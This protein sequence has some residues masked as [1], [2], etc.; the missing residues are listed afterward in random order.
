MIATIAVPV[1][2]S[3][4]SLSSFS[5]VSTTY[6]TGSIISQAI[7][8]HL[9]DFFGRVPGLMVCF[10]LFAIGTTLCG[11]APTLPYFLLGRSLQGIGGGS[12]CSIT[13]VL[14]TDIVPVQQRA[15]LEGLGNLF[16][17]VVLAVGGIYGAFT[18]SLSSWRWAFLLQVPVIVVDGIVI[19]R[20]ANVPDKRVEEFSY[21]EVDIVGI[22]SL[23]GTIILSEYGL[24][25]A[26]TTMIWWSLPVAMSLSISAMCLVMF[27]YWESS[28]AKRPV[29]P[30]NALIERSVAAIQI[31][32]FLSTGCLASVF[33]YVP[34]FLDTQG[35]SDTEKS[36]RFIPLAISFGL[37]GIITGHIVQRTN[38]YYHSNLV[39]QLTSTVAYAFLCTLHQSSTSWKPFLYL[40][41]LGFGVG[42]SYVTN[43]LGILTCVSEEDLTTIQSA[44]WSVRS[45]G[46]AFGLVTS[47][48]IFQSVLRA[49]LDTTELRRFTDDH[50]I[51]DSA[52]LSEISKLP[53]R[54]KEAYIK[55]YGRATHAVFYAL[56]AQALVG[57]ISCLFIQD[58]LVQQNTLPGENSQV[59]ELDLLNDDRN[60]EETSWEVQNDE[61][62]EMVN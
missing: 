58:R 3:L 51:Q 50:G 32:A 45:A 18:T 17:G 7:S 52:D 4:A 14:E 23:L 47:S 6:L 26:S 49:S 36:L 28:R 48:V 34:I 8:G 22:V 15:F 38:R 25:L 43:L 60:S 1:T 54:Y 42:G 55:G 9:V 37:S 61:P 20:V 21:H 53:N 40:G 29:V 13:S 59:H 62:R 16:Y 11:L 41:L 39:L 46:V 12:I 24:N 5:W 44:S 10:C 30:V 35:F 33:F 27:I 31:S 57:T 19:F 2:T 56:F